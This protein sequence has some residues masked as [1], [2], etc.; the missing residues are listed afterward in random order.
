VINDLGYKNR[1]QGVTL[2]EMMIALAVSA[3]VLTLVAPN[4][5]SI[6]V[7]NKITAEINEMSGVLQFARFT[8]IDQ[9]SITI[10]CPSSD[11]S[12]CG[13]NWDDPK[14]VFIDANANDARDADE[15][16]LL[17]SQTIANTNSMDSSAN[18][19]RFLD[20]GGTDTPSVITLCPNSNDAKYARALFVTLQGRTRISIDADRDGTHEDNNGDN[21]SC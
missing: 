8:A 18:L 14:I 4:V 1:Q 6:L 21:I 10:V 3:I 7:K 2:L 9:R 16:L 15:P 12:S 5:Q 20:I 11:F 13:N 19:I 17:S